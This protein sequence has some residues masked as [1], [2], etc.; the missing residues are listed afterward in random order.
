MPRYRVR[1][2]LE[3]EAKDREEAVKEAHIGVI[4]GT[5]SYRSI[6]KQ[7]FKVRVTG[8]EEIR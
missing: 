8:T 4:I 6:P 7:K 3:V 1:V 5:M 2:E